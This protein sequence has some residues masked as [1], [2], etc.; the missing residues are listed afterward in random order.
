MIPFPAPGLRERKDAEVKRAFFEAAME[1]FQEK[2]FD[3]TT[4]DEIAAKVG[5]SRATFFNHFGTKKGVFRYYG[6]RLTERVGAVLAGVDR[7]LSP[8]E[9]IRE[10]LFAM[11]READA[12]RDTVRVVFLHSSSDPD[13]LSGPSPARRRI[14]DVVTALTKEAQEKGQVR[15]DMPPE[16]LAFHT[17]SLYHSSVVALVWELADAE[18][19]MESAWQFLLTGVKGEGPVTD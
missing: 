18:T 6:Q 15:R 19:T 5:Y 4:V 10:I 11:A 14:A 12:H 3:A 17:L 7:A 13:Y 8:L 16:A 2:G 1:L 9:R